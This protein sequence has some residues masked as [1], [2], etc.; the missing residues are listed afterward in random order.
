MTEITIGK[1]YQVKYRRTTIT[2]T[3]DP[4]LLLYAMQHNKRKKSYIIE[5]DL[6]QFI[7]FEMRQD[8]ASKLI[9]L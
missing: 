6:Q 7:E 4:N 9:E 1:N 8:P 5:K 2:W 3:W